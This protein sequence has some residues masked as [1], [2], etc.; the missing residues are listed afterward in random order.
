MVPLT[1][2]VFSIALYF[3]ETCFLKPEKTH[4]SPVPTGLGQNHKQYIAPLLGETLLNDKI[5]TSRDTL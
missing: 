2:S 3:V 4:A 5:N 1:Y